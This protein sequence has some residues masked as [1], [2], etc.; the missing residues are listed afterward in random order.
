VLAANIVG[1]AEPSDTSV[2]TI[3]HKSNHYK[4]PSAQLIT[5]MKTRQPGS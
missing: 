3:F 1:S 2:P 5:E 4:I